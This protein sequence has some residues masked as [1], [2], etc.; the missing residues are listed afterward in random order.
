MSTKKSYRLKNLEK[1]LGIMTVGGFLRSWR[2]SEEY[3]QQESAKE[4]GMPAANLCDI[5]KGRKGV[6]PQKA[7]EIAEAIGYSPTILIELALKEQLREAGLNYDIE[8]KPSSK[9]AVS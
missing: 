4:L 3:T 7:A 9:K 2:E 1:K 6:S 5:E 8:V